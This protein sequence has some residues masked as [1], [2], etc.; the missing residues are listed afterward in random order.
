MKKYFKIGIG[1]L[2]FTGVGA[3]WYGFSYVQNQST[4]TWL[5]SLQDR[6]PDGATFVAEALRANAD[7]HDLDRKNNGVAWMRLGVNLNL[8]GEKEEALKAY[9]KALLQDETNVLVLN[10]VANLYDDLGRYEES[11]AAWLKLISLYPDRTATY[12]S[13]GYLYEYR[14][15]KTSLE[16]E[17]LFQVGLT[18]TN[19]SSDL[20][21]WLMSYFLETGNNEKFVEYANILNEKSKAK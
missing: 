5:E 8:L 17:A 4:I 10:N 2:V 3:G 6:H 16:I 15:R 18:A 7:L 12:R 14:M 13:L 21:S 11:E 1:L 20:L 9:K 19:N